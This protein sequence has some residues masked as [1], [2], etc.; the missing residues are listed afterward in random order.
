MT[1]EP[2]HPEC[3]L[4]ADWPL[5]GHVHAG[6]TTRLGGYSKTP[7]DTLNLGEHVGDIQ[8]D[9]SRNRKYL[10][11]TVALPAEPSWLKQ[12]H[13]NRVVEL[14]KTSFNHEADGAY[15]RQPGIIC[16]VLTADCVPVLLSSED[17]Q[18]IA[19]VHAGWRGFSKD[20]IASAIAHFI[21]PGPRISAWIG[22]CIGVQHYETDENIKKSCLEV[23][24]SGGDAFL[25]SRPGHCLTDLQKL[26]Q[27]RLQE[28]GVCRIYGGQYCTYTHSRLFYSY[29][30]EGTTGRFASLIWM[31]S[32]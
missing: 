17:G 12:T 28:L 15:T 27:Q 19:A 1:T 7:Y 14:A 6:C 10:I 13:G 29:R 2:N 23:A 16:T 11:D 4:P 5:P 18:E 3:W 24:G 8:A 20:I 30:K 25:P 9:V 26:V 22:P 32:G 21:S 31:D